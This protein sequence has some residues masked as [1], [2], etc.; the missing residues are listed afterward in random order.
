MYAQEFVVFCFVVDMIPTLANLYTIHVFTH[1]IVLD[2]IISNGDISVT[3][4]HRGI[5]TVASVPVKLP[6]R[7]VANSTG[8]LFIKR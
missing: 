4:L 5:I 3:L 8:A 2:Y 6:R 1:N 7:K